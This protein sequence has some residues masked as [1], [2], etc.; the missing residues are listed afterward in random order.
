MKFFIYG[1]NICDHSKNIDA[2][3]W[4]LP[5]ITEVFDFP[6]VLANFACPLSLTFGTHAG[7]NFSKENGSLRCLQNLLAEK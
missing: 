2:A 5:K 3:T 4:K 6:P 7:W 1:C